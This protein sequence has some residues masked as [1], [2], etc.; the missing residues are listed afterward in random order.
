MAIKKG[1]FEGFW[2]IIDSQDEYSFSQELKDLIKIMLSGQ[3]SMVHNLLSHNWFE[4][5]RNSINQNKFANYE[6]Y[7]KNELA[8]YKRGR[9][10]GFFF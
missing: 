7:M 6:Q 4:K 1:N 2:M 10:D 8:C 9:D 5:I 3:I